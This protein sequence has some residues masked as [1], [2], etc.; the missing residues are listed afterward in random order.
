ML[1]LGDEAHRPRRGER[2]GVVAARLHQSPED[3]RAWSHMHMVTAWTV[4]G[5]SPEGGRPRTTVLDAH[6]C[7]NLCC[8]GL[9]SLVHRAAA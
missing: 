3:E 9:Q 1:A 8:L 2:R 6:G 4:Y 7:C 5:C